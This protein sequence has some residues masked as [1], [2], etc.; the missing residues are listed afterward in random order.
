MNYTGLDACGALLSVARERYV[1]KPGFWQKLR[2]KP[3]TPVAFVEADMAQPL[4]APESLDMVWS[5]MALHWHP[6]PHRV[7][8]EWR[9]LLKP[10]ALVMFSCLGPGSLKELRQAIHDAQLDTAIA[11][12]VDMVSPIQS[13]IRKPLPS[14]TAPPRSCCKTCLSL[15]AT[16]AWTGGAGC[17]GAAG[18]SGCSM[19]F[20][21][22]AI[23]TAPYT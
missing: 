12:F 8:A 14:P 2:N 13:W 5:N 19:R 23:S 10:D 15:A 17:L 9:R 21:P 7:L 22:S 11:E 18:A 20:P 16:P 6:E 1:A 3:T 4:L